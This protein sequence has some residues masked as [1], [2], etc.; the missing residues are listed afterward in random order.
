LGGATVPDAADPT[1]N[2]V[3]TD[4][5]GVINV[6]V[7]LAMGDGYASAVLRNKMFAHRKCSITGRFR[8]DIAPGSL[9]KIKTIG[10][11][12]VSESEELY[13]H[14]YAVFLRGEPGR[15]E[16]T[17]SVIAVRT[18]AEHDSLTVDKHPLFEKRWVGAML[19]D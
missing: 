16:T 15:M 13:G 10:E 2:Y 12:F 1:T 5:G 19:T 6:W 3:E 14:A 4:F 18:Q 17:V 8:L 7:K 9:V 11:R